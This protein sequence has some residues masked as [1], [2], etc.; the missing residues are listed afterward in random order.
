[1]HSIA[2]SIVSLAMPV[3]AVVFIKP[4]PVLWFR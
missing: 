2:V 1:M 4:E 3:I